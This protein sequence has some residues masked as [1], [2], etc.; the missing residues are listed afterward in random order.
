MTRWNVYE[1]DP[2]GNVLVDGVKCKL[3]DVVYYDSACGE[4]WILDGL[5]NHDGYNE[6]IK[7]RKG[8]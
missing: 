3:I 2:N 5:I 6:N 8:K 7:I 1:P 4:D